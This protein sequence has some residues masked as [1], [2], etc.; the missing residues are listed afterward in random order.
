LNENFV[1]VPQLADKL[2]QFYHFDEIDHYFE[3]IHN[4][5]LVNGVHIL[6]GEEVVHFLQEMQHED[7]LNF[8]VLPDENFESIHLDEVDHML[9]E[10]VNDFCCV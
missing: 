2:Y 7:V 1:E 9:H 8:L 4:Y 6:M 10:R 5:V 3:M